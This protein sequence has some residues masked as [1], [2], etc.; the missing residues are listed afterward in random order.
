MP[1]IIVDLCS[2]IT[3]Y[4]SLTVGFYA[5]NEFYN[6]FKDSV[7]DQPVVVVSAGNQ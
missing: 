4:I 1:K 3:L 7:E 5:V 2:I 6:I